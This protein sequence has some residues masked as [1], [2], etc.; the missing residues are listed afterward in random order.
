MK[1]R[2]ERNMKLKKNAKFWMCI[3]LLVCLLSMVLASA[4]QGS[5]GRVKVS[6][7]RLVDRAGYEVSA[8]LYKPASATP[9]NPAPCIIT[10]E[11]WYNNK[12]MQDLYSVEYARRGYVVLAV[13][14]H[15]HGDSENTDS[16]DL[17]T[18]A[19]G[20]DAAVELAG[21]MPYVDKTRIGV[22]G[23]SSGGA[24]CGMAVAIDNERDTPL[25][26]A[27]LYEASTWVDDTGVDHSADLD[28][29]Y[30]GIIAD[31]YDEFFY[32]TVDE[33]GND[34]VPLQFLTTPDAKNFVNFNNGYEGVE[35]VV[36]GQYYEQDG[37]FR[38]IWQPDCTHPWVHFS[39]TSVGHGI[40][41][42][43][44]AFG[45]PNPI[46]ANNQVWQWKTT[47]NF[48]GLVGIIMFV[49]S[50]ICVMLD[51]KYFSV[52]KAE[53]EPQPVT[54]ND[55]KGKLWFWIPLVLCAAFSG[56]S[57]YWTI[58]NVYS[59]T[60]KFF[61]QTGPL[62]TGVWCVLSGIFCLVILLVYYY[63]FGKKN[64]FVPAERGVTISLSKLWRTVVLA[65][66]TTGL[67]FLILFCADYF[68][69]S[70]F[71]LWVLTLKAFDADKVI[72]GLRY[73]PLFLCFYIINSV[74]INCFNFNNIGGKLNILI[75]SIF[76]CLGALVF[77]AIQ[78]GTFFATGALKW[79]STEGYRISGI[80]LYPAI[81]YL[82]VTPFM[83]RFIYKKT[84][85]PYLCAIVNAI[86]ITMM[87]VA[88]TTTVLGGGAVVAANY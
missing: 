45:A 22:T 4:I 82:F 16:A 33:N 5:F 74:S 75:M 70:D 53:S 72:I 51:T 63:C 83:T 24:A 1:G 3:A 88:N 43:E 73:L 87:C 14:M 67:A 66:L 15:G 81:I 30:V 47:F 34:T 6:E 78:Y 35:D 58:T 49:L 32:W 27:V 79:Y 44:D 42:F 54:V 60:T 52:L 20:L 56:L 9:E 10:V 76:N 59:K 23:H 71:R 84:K 7:L 61:V 28:G 46:A 41:F 57:Y 86:L 25:I 68:F 48:A 26:S 21:M 62:T 19:V 31:K 64:G 13:D 8:L 77:V 69:K 17:Y 80:W 12:E 36:P 39:A 11:G 65:V 37:L 85:N 29:R 50:F 38:V 55:G 18:A 2:K 40:Q